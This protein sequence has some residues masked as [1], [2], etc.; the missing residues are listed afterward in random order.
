MLTLLYILVLLLSPPKSSNNFDKLTGA[1]TVKLTNNCNQNL[2]VMITTAS[3]ENSDL[4][5]RHM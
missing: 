1:G 4:N 5:Y 3:I 2:K